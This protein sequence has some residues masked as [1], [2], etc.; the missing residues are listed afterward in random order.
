MIQTF[1][2]PAQAAQLEEYLEANPE[3]ALV[4]NGAHISVLTGDTLAAYLARDNA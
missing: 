2:Y 4:H 1:E 3:H